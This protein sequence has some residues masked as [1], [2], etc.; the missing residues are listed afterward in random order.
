MSSQ[1]TNIRFVTIHRSHT[2]YC[3]IFT[4]ST[5]I[6]FTNVTTSTST[7][8]IQFKPT[9]ISKGFKF[10][11]A[12]VIEYHR[13]ITTKPFHPFLDKH[14][15][16]TKLNSVNETSGCNKV[17]LTVTPKGSTIVLKSKVKMLSNCFLLLLSLCLIG[18]NN[19]WMSITD[20]I[21]E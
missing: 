13:Q 12:S 5:I 6:V 4:L 21:S 3:I 19:E 7:S 14:Y 9:L 20:D 2:M 8:K 15:K 10:V 1:T 17:Y 11:Q 18:I 16:Q